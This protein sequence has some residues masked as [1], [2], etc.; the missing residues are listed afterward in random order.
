MVFLCLVLLAALYLVVDAPPPLDELG[1]PGPTVAVEDALRLC[2]AE[3]ATVRELYT[4]AIVGPGLAAGL[5]FDESWRDATVEAGPLPALF[6]REVAMSLERSPA[7]LGLFLGS[8]FPIR[9]ANRFSGPQAE[10]FG[11]LRTSGEAQFFFDPDTGRHTAMFPD[12]AVAPA[13]VNC[14]NEHPESPKQDWELGEIMG[15]TTWTHPQERITTAELLSLLGA[16][17]RSFRDAYS[18]YLEEAASFSRPPE[19]GKRWPA[20]GY[21]LPDLETFMAEVSSRTAPASLEA[22]IAR[23]GDT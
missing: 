9:Q 5:A 22:L 21:F 23:L 14:H 13:C 2:A 19:I 20:E 11:A 7:P 10:A 18:A 12:L 3:N 15:A 17:R 4:R 16:L 1:D 6:L 8:D